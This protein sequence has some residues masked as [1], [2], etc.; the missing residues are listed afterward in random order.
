MTHGWVCRY[1]TDGSGRIAYDELKKMLNDLNITSDGD[2]A[3]ALLTIIDRQ[4]PASRSDSLLAH[5][6]NLADYFSQSVCLALC[7]CARLKGLISVCCRSGTGSISYTD[8]VKDVLQ[9]SEESLSKVAYNR[10]HL[11]W[12]H[13][14]QKHSGPILAHEPILAP[15]LVVRNGSLA[16][17]EH[18][19]LLFYQ[20]CVEHSNYEDQTPKQTTRQS[21]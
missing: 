10:A 8:F 6:T 3:A 16:G 20:N 21:L 17:C 14:S 9:L 5:C 11:C 7:R 2:A 19:S 1:D 4:F 15:N 12:T 13:S 18:P